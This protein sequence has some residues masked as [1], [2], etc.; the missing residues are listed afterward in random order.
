VITFT[1]TLSAS[2]SEGGTV[3]GAGSFAIGASRTVT[4]ATNTGFTFA[5]WTSNSIVVSTATSYTFTL[6]SDRNLVAN[7]LPAKGAYNGLLYD[8]NGIS[9]ASCGFFTITTTGKGSFTGKLQ[10]GAAKYVA[11]G[12]MSGGGAAHVSILRK[13]LSTL[14][15]DLQ[16]D[17]ADPDRITGTLSDTGTPIAELTG[18]RAVFDKNANPAPQAGKYTWIIPGDYNAAINPGGDSFGTISVDA[19]GKAKV[20][21]SLADGTKMSQLVP[22]SKNGQL[23]FFGSLYGGAGSILSWINFSNAP[24]ED[25]SGDVSWIKPAIAT[26]KYYPGGFTLGMTASGSRYTNSA[27]GTNILNMTDG[28]LTLSGGNLPQNI[29]NLVSL[30]ANNK[31]TNSSINKLTLTFTP[32]TGLFK[33]TVV[34]PTALTSKPISFSGVALQKQNVACGFSPGTNQTAR[35]FLEPVP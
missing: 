29:T 22:V 23:P 15:L 25:L 1:I 33:G 26:A 6:N 19:G 30:L 31:I 12:P 3:S 35:V 8:T 34:N 7:F 9:Q 2:P 32:T 13:N 17:L 24:A 27:P 16:I 21:V 10:V 28:T 20:A 11:T 4:A 18:D 14:T 5:N